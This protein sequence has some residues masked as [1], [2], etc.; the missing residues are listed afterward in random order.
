MKISPSA[1]TST[2]QMFLKDSSLFSFPSW[3]LPKARR[4]RK[5]SGGAIWAICFQTLAQTICWWF[6]WRVTFKN[7]THSWAPFPVFLFQCIKWWIP[8]FLTPGTSFAEDNSSTDPGGVM[9]SGWFKYITFIVLRM[10]CICSHST[11][12][13]S[14]PQLHL[15][16][17]ASRF[18]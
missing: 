1:S 17:A 15:R 11:A 13:A 6:I 14:P 8:T 9:D 10:T 4:E 7:H 12:L 5:A 2:W 3:L 16:S 18:S